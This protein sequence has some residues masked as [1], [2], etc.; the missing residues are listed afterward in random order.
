MPMPEEQ[1]KEGQGRDQEG[2]LDHSRIEVLIDKASQLMSG[3]EK[4]AIAE[5]MQYINNPRRVIFFNF[6]AGLSRGFG[7]AVGFTLLGAMFIYA[8][9][10]V[11]SWNLPVIGQYIADIVKIV[12]QRLR[13]EGGI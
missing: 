8:L 3:L 12:M 11:V 6:L 9:S 7:M 1:E 4:S 13:F 5:Y 2:K 10:S